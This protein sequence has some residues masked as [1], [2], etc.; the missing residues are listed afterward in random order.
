MPIALP[1]SPGRKT[2][3]TM[4]MFVPKIIA[5]EKP[6]KILKRII[7]AGF[8]EKTIRT[9]EMLNRNMPNEKIFFRPVI[10]A[11]LPKGS[12]KTADAR[13]KLLMIHPSSTAFAPNSLPIA[14]R[15]RLTEDPK[16]AVRKVV[17]D[18]TMRTYILKDFSLS[19][20]A[21]SIYSVPML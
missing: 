10:S 14:G 9:D 18:V 16:K 1:L 12:R 21:V 4:A 5:E 15:A 20:S 6:W 2:A 19:E 3:V 8:L 13:M 7:M 17:I 11:S